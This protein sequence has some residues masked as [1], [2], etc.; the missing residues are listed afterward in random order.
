MT[1]LQAATTRQT[2]RVDRLLAPYIPD[3]VRWEVAR[4]ILED[5]LDEHWRPFPPAPPTRQPNT[6]PNVAHRGADYA[7]GLLGRTDHDA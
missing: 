2:H 7:R 5:F 3:A 4:R 6:D 1:E